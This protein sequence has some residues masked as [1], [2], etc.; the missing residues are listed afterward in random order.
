MDFVRLGSDGSNQSVNY[1][2]IKV[3]VDKGELEV[4]DALITHFSVC[5]WVR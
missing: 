5:G 3:K 2:K 1:K 4:D